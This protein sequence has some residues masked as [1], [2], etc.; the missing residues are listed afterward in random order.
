[1][2]PRKQSEE[3][4]TGKEKSIMLL[5]CLMIWAAKDQFYWGFSEE[6]CRMC[7]KIVHLKDVRLVPLFSISC[8][9]SIIED[10]CR[11]W[12]VSHPSSL[13]WHKSWGRAFG[14]RESSEAEEWRNACPELLV[15]HCHCV[16]NWHHCSCDHR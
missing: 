7:S 4:E 9:V 5:S 10:C 14:F 2:N 1:M 3:N 11:W 8:L 16:Q 6:F 12:Q 15:E 13:P